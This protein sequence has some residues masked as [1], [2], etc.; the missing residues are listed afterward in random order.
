LFQC[1]SFFDFAL[2]CKVG[3]WSENVSFVFYCKFFYLANSRAKDVARYG[4]TRSFYV[5][6]NNVDKQ[7]STTCKSNWLASI[8]VPTNQVKTWLG[9]TRLTFWKVHVLH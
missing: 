7:S 6:E 5:E 2:L 9:G 4:S 1:D 3:L 8:D